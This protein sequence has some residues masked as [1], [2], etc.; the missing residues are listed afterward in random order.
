M[1]RKVYDK[2]LKWKAEDQG[3]VAIM[4]DGA[5]RVGKSYI[6]REFAKEYKSAIFVDFSD[7]SQSLRH[8][9]TAT[10]MTATSCFFN[11][12]CISM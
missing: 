5:R 9:S 1:R 7:M 8:T 6:A 12:S 3:R 4:L 10:C 2:L 11:S